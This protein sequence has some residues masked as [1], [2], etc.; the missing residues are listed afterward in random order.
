MKEQSSHHSARALRSLLLSAAAVLVL[1]GSAA[2]A[3]SGIITEK[4]VNARTGPGTQYD[5]VE[6]LAAGKQVTILG[7]ENGWYQISW[8]K[9]KGYV[10]KDYVATNGGA[11]EASSAPA[12][13]TDA[14]IT[15]GSIIN[16]RSGPGTGYSRLGQVGAG[17]RVKVLGK[18]G[19]W[20]KITYDGRTGYVLTNYL[21]PDGSSAPVKADVP[22]AP[23]PAA[24]NS[25]ATVT[26]GSSINVRTGPGTDYSRVTRVSSGKRVEI[27]GQDSGWYQ[28]SFDGK[29]GYISGEYVKPD[30][31]AL[32]IVR[33][34]SAPA[35]P[36]P[37]EPA[38]AEAAPAEV[39]PEAPAEPEP[40]TEETLTAAESQTLGAPS[41]AP[42]QSGGNGFIVGGTINVRTG[43]G[44]EFDR[45][46][47]LT[48]G[49][50]VTIE[51][52][53]GD[54]YR[55][56]FDGGEGYVHGEYIREGDLQNS[57]LGAQ[58]AELALQYQGVRYVYGGT[59]PSGFDCSGFTSY[60]YRQFGYSLPHTASGQYANCGY[61]VSRSELQPGDLVFFT[62]SG[63][64]GRINHVGVYIG[65]DQVIHAR[66]SIGKVYIN[67]LSET[68]YNKN[69]V[70]AIRIA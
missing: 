11:A 40:E 16:V 57:G 5:R 31:S 18:E 47:K 26:G 45:V 64:G 34:E 58:V 19:D 3:E 51:G 12:A 68:Y 69:Y 1:C 60:L 10:C 63:N 22:A 2:A 59:S 62:S 20:Y 54:W 9:S 27:T 41:G 13:D 23:A 8:N 56:S 38:P 50:R 48:T 66:F 30:D 52:Q 55:I 17:K 7:E 32:A 33:E 70:G 6:L 29:T 44:T 65:G 35:E 49:K 14:A 61:K 37:A 25:N 67:S 42:A 21:L 46:T 15:G 24:Q 43:P 28:V 36:A 39:A 4:V 53:E